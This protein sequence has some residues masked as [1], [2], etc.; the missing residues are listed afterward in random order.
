MFDNRFCAVQ[1]LS[2]AIKHSLWH[3]CWTNALHDSR[4]VHIARILVW[5]TLQARRNSSSPP[6]I[7][8]NNLYALLF[9]GCL[10]HLLLSIPFGKTNPKSVLAKYNPETLKTM[11]S[12][13]DTLVWRTAKKM[14]STA[15]TLVSGLSSDQKEEFRR[16]SETW[17]A[18]YKK[19]IDNRCNS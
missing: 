1:C 7:E 17:S 8:G 19:E 5:L 2:A 3:N 9:L 12:A 13:V 18:Y 6:L 14:K 11:A 4:I 10:P 16:F 15:H